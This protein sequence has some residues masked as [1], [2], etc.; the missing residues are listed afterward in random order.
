MVD[1]INMTKCLRQLKRG[2][3][4]L[5]APDSG[6]EPTLAGKT[7]Q[8]ELVESLEMEACGYHITSLVWKKAELR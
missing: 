5:L 2:E 8:L 4:F 7:R 1:L 3:R 6:L